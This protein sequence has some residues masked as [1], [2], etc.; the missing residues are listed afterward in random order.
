VL[1]TTQQNQA[2]RGYALGLS[3]GFR[4]TLH[5]L[6]TTAQASAL[7]GT[8]MPP[9]APQAPPEMSGPTAPLSRSTRGCRDS[10]EPSALRTSVPWCCVPGTSALWPS[11]WPRADLEHAEA[12]VAREADALAVKA[13]HEG[14]LPGA[15]AAVGGS[16]KRGGSCEG[17]VTT[18]TRGGNRGSSTLSLALALSL[19]WGC[20]DGG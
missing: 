4:C 18:T 20:P 12:A 11:S 15:G 10:R 5:L 19:S 2:V 6:R 17:S 8:W 16:R 13:H 14:G 3:S 9:L 7:W 1:R